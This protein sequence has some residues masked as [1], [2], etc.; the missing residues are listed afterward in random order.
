MLCRHE[1]LSDAIL[2][3]RRIGRG[4]VT[5]RR[6]GEWEERSLCR[7]STRPRPSRANP[8]WRPHYEFRFFRPSNRLRAG[9]RT[10]YQNASGVGC[11]EQ[12]KTGKISCSE[13]ISRE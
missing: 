4:P 10:S 12:H 5:K 11:R 3:E 2:E 6:G 9:L 8:G 13:K 1:T 7:P